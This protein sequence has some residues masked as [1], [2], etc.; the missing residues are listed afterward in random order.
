MLGTVVAVGYLLPGAKQYLAPSARKASWGF[1]SKGLLFGLFLLLHVMFSEQNVRRR[2]KNHRC[3][4]GGGLLAAHEN[5]P[6]K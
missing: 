4:R 1:S 5:T 2:I 6:A 3:R